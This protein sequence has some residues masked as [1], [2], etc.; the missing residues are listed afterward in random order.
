VAV[1][2]TDKEVEARLRETAVSAAVGVVD[3]DHAE[4]RDSLSEY[5]EGSMSTADTDRVRQHLDACASCQA[6]WRTLLKVVAET[7]QLPAAALSEQARRRLLDG[8]LSAPTS[9]H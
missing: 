5:L 8:A 1:T 7:G 6:F 3:I 9:S 2:H 4:V